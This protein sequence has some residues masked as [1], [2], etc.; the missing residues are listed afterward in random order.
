MLRLVA[1]TLPLTAAL[2]DDNIDAGTFEQKVYESGVSVAFLK[3]HTPW[4]THC[5]KMEPD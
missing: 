2:Y 5:R 4:C 3:F 1:L